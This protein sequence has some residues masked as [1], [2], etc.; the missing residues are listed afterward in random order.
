MKR[1][2]IRGKQ[3]ISLHEETIFSSESHSH[4]GVV[5][6]RMNCQLQTLGAS[7]SGT[8]GMA[9]MSRKVTG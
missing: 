8:V 1:R 9:E 5:I 6:I 3:T 7:V 2:I 4:I